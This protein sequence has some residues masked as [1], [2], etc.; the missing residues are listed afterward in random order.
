MPADLFD[1]LRVRAALGR[2]YTNDEDKAGASSVAVLSYGLW[3]RRFGG[4]ASVI[5]RALTL[6]DR[7]YTVIGVMPQAFLFPSGV[8]MWVPAGLLS[9]QD[10]WK[11]RG[12]HPGLAA[13]GS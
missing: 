13:V 10:V 8:E 2:A 5:G 3:Q 12:S 6:N 9:D 11:H 7:S 4:D 1:A